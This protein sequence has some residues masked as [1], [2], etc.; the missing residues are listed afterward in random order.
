LPGQVASLHAAKSFHWD[1]DP[2]ASPEYYQAIA[3]PTSVASI[4]ERLIREGYGPGGAPVAALFYDD[5]RRLAGNCFSY[6][7]AEPFFAG[8]I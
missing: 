5:L 7:C 8:P 3:R 1:I 2:I 4:A 6:R